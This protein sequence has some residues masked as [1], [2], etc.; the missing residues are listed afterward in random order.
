[1]GLRADI[2]ADIAE[3]FDSDLADAVTSFTASHPGSPAYDPATGSVTATP[4]PYTGRGV[5]GDYRADHIDGTVILA[6]DKQ[7]IALQNDVARAPAV[8]DTIAGMSAVRVEQ[9]PAAATWVV[10]LRA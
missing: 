2:Q 10:Q 3:A 6:T 1:M 7:L 8:G 5:F 4:T 9:D